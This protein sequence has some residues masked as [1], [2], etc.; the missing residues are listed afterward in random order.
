VYLMRLKIELDRRLRF[1]AVEYDHEAVVFLAIMI[2][3]SPKFQ[4]DL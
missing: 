4:Q 3:R 1:L 2:G